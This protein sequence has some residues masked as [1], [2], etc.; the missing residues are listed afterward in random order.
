MEGDS[1]SDYIN[2][3]VN[4]IQNRSFLKYLTCSKMLLKLY[5]R[6]FTH[7]RRPLQNDCYQY[8]D[9]NSTAPKK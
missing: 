1:Q 2:Y 7:V 6:E 3:F 4:N 9:I 8:N 5:I